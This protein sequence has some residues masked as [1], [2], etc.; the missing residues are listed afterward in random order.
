MHF[1]IFIYSVHP[2]VWQPQSHDIEPIICFLGTSL[3]L[4]NRARAEMSLI[5]WSVQG[6]VNRDRGIDVQGYD[7]DDY[8][9]VGKL[10]RGTT[11]EL[12]SL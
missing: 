9:R 3:R 2:A 12:Y 7:K 5:P 8:F 6:H 11:P 10:K 1:I 4:L